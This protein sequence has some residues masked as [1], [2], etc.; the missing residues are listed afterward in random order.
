MKP[1]HFIKAKEPPTI[2]NLALA[3]LKLGADRFVAVSPAFNDEPPAVAIFLMTPKAIC[4]VGPFINNHLKKLPQQPCQEGEFIQSTPETTM[5][6][7]FSAL[8]KLG[9]EWVYMDIPTPAGMGLITIIIGDSLTEEF[10]AELTKRG[11]ICN[12]K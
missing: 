8:R 2:T 5:R 9:H 6:Q 3:G 11:A 7:L 10:A 4:E 1:T 12:L